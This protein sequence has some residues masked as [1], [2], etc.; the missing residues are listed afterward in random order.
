MSGNF[1]N[2]FEQRNEKHKC[3]EEEF[4]YVERLWSD[5]VKALEYIIETAQYLKTPASAKLCEECKNEI[6]RLLESGCETDIIGDADTGGH[7]L[8]KLLAKAAEIY[9]ASLN[10]NVRT[11][12]SA[13]SSIEAPSR[14]EHEISKEAFQKIE[15]LCKHQADT[16]YS[17]AEISAYFKNLV[18][19]LKN[20][21]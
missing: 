18:R 12:M 6:N 1:S 13:V 11:L 20:K 16:A 14:W 2:L 10:K 17:A 8:T 19:S 15:I 7:A 9:A 5:T 21:K 4:R 3:S